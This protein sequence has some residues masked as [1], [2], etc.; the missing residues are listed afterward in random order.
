MS[1][2]GSSGSW[3]W[4]PRVGNDLS[5]FIGQQV[6]ITTGQMQGQHPQHIIFDEAAAMDPDADLICPLCSDIVP[7]QSAAWRDHDVR[8]T[9]VSFQVCSA[10][11]SVSLCPADMHGIHGEVIED[12]GWVNETPS[13][14]TY[15]QQVRGHCSRCRQ[16][17]V[18]D[19]SKQQWCDPEP[20]PEVAEIVALNARLQCGDIDLDSYVAE[21]QRLT[22]LEGAD[23]AA[24]ADS[25]TTDGDSHGNERAGRLPGRSDQDGSA[26]GHG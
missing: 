6:H 23:Q 20:D 14:L 18:W 5:A 8:G 25:E 19:G 9:K 11:V 10:C 21:L 17:M 2:T 26:D 15:L 24:D 7:I 13:G 3:S 22:A 1:N 4:L 16:P 12:S